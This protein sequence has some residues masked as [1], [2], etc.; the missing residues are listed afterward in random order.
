MLH[1]LKKVF[2]R[3]LGIVLI[4]AAALTFNYAG[5]ELLPLFRSA[6]AGHGEIFMSFLALSTFFLGIPTL[7]VVGFR[8]L[9]L[10]SFPLTWLYFLALP[11]A[12][13]I[14]V[15]SNIGRIYDLDAL[16]SSVVWYTLVFGLVVYLLRFMLLEFYAPISHEK[17]H[18]VGLE[19]PNRPKT[20]LRALVFVSVGVAL[21]YAHPAQISDTLWMLFS[22]VTHW[23]AYVME[24]L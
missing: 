20:T 21:L 14:Y 24:H 15:L 5:R 7:L 12:H 6:I 8:L 22:P 13:G 23:A 9:Y 11:T 1:T 3:F 2:F 16:M 19:L 10:R 18:H 4:G 17:L